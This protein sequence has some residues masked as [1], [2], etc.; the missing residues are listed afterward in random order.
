MS[1]E[2]DQHGDIEQVVICQR[3]LDGDSAARA[4][5]QRVID[6]AAIAKARGA[7]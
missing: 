4:E 6:R 1:D 3:A 7:A 2:A 5:C